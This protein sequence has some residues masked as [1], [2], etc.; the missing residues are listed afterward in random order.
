LGLNETFADYEEK[1]AEYLSWGVRLIWLVD[2][3]TETV[4]VIRQNGER[5]VLKGKDVLSGEDV[6]PG[7]KIR[8]KTIF[9]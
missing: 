2:P 5:Q 9:A 3:N 8:V 7:F 6:V 4:M 1:V